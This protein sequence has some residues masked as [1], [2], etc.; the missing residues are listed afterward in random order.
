MSIEVGVILAH[1]TNRLLV[2]DGNVPPPAN[3]VAY[4]GRVNNARP[5][6]VT[7]LID[8]PVPWVEPDAVDWQGLESLE[9]TNLSLCDFA[10][11]FPRLWTCRP[12]TPG[13]LPATAS[14]G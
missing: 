8:I 13:A 7:D 1:L 14:I 6:R 3:I 11:Y 4:D 5:S 9:L 2:L 12:A 10:F